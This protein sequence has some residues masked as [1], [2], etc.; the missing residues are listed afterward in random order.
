MPPRRLE[1]CFLGMRVMRV[2]RVIP[3]MTVTV[4]IT[5]HGWAAAQSFPSKPMR[6]IVPFAPGGTTDLLAR[7]VAEKMG[8][9]LGQTVIV[10]NKAGVGGAIGAAQVAKAVPDGYT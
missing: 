2:M 6:L 9:A 8:P 10:E 1:K 3:M 7:I 5:L 4:V